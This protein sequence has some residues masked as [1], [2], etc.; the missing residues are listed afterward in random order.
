[1]KNLLFYLFA[2]LAMV[3]AA[4]AGTISA[5]QQEYVVKY[6]DRQK[7]KNLPAPEAMLLNTE[8]EPGLANGFRPLFNGKDL[9]GWN[10]KG[11]TC[12][13]EVKDSTI[14]GTTIPKSP[15]TFLCTDASFS[16]FIFTCDMKW[17]VDGNSGIMFRARS[18][19]GDKSFER[20]YGPQCEMEGVNN[21]RGW[22][23]GIYGEA[24]GGWFYP[25]WLEAHEEV[26][27]A[28]NADG[29]NRVTIKAEGGTVKTWV[30]GIPAAH[31]QTDEYLDGFIG[32]QVHSGKQGEIL[33]RNIR[34]KEL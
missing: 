17:A 13:Y 3:S 9:S 1:M 26:R 15:N 10:L 29:W 8:A 30:N 5:G 28:I 32:L 31:W 4:E 18:R 24:A 23:G 25:L 16:D 14:V 27:N 12:T 22:S 21:P 34:I 33:W 7:Q 6:R 19:T 11:G 2:P 20:V